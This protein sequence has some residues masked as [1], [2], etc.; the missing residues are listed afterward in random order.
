MIF[1]LHDKLQRKLGPQNIFRGVKELYLTKDIPCSLVQVNIFR[2]YD[3]AEYVYLTRNTYSTNISI[4][5]EKKLFS[6]L[7]YLRPQTPSLNE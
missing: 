2:F 7:T 4:F 1:F 3:P 5:V 6:N